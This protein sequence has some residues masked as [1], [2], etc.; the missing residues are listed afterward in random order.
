[1]F[2]LM[3]YEE[4][5]EHLKLDRKNEERDKLIMKAVFEEIA[6]FIVRPLQYQEDTIELLITDELGIFVPRHYP[7]REFLR[8]RDQETSKELELAEDAIIPTIDSVQ[9]LKQIPYRLAQPGKKYLDI[10]YMYG[11]RLEEMPAMVKKCVLDMVRDE[12]ENPVTA[13]EKKDAHLYRLLP[14][15]REEYV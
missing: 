2:A 6:L 7:V 3:T 1:M 13:L 10:S 4:V 11:Y 9:A 8:I 12:I 5:V 14:F 15:C